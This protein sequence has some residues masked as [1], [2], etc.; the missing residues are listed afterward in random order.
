MASFV[1]DDIVLEASSSCIVDFIEGFT[2]HFVPKQVVQLVSTL[3]SDAK[4]AAQ[5]CNNRFLVSRLFD[6]LQG[7]PPL[8]RRP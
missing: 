8:I 2:L 6:T 7:L 4:A 5:L 1:E 3:A